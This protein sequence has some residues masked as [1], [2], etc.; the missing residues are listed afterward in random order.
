MK[1]KKKIIV[2]FG[3]RPEIIK[4]APII[5]ILKKKKIDLILLYSGQ[6]YSKN[7]SEIFLKKF[8]INRIN[9]N[10]K[11]GK[12]YK[13][14]KFINIFYSK[15]KKIL[16]IENPDFVIVQGDTNTCLVSALAT[17]SFNETNNFNAKIAHVE[18]GLRSYDMTMPEETNR[19]IVDHISHI[20]FPPTKIQ[21][22]ILNKEGIKKNIHVVGSTIVDNLLNKKILKLNKKFFLLTIHRYENVSNKLRLIKILKIMGKIAKIFNTKVYFP[23]HPNTQ[24]KIKLYKI[25]INEN[26]KILDP[27]DYDK[28]L[29]LLKNSKVIFSD[30]GG[31]Q[32]E[33]CIL[34]KHLIT[35]RDNT[36]RPE[37]I[38]IN[39]NY[40]SMLDERKIFNRL[41]KIFSHKISWKNHPYGKN[42]SN[43]IVQTILDY[44]K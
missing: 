5:E 1:K 18:A 21:E 19:I 20:L 14:K 11:L 33:A 15:F 3:T 25:K 12:K 30:S 41:K 6:H 26:I 42:V 28:F 35:F 9:Y 37:T 10:L 44:G 4:L 24:D 23:C 38:K 32:E 29:L 13:S 2:S 27:I 7:M 34:K 16:K 36:E 39:A 40:L 43:K 22:K 17:K 31:L 8:K